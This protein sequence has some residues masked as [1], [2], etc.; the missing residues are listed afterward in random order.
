M[1][2]FLS[3]SRPTARK[4][5]ECSLCTGAIEVGQVYHRSVY[6]GDAEIYAW[7]TCPACEVDNVSGYVYDYVYYVEE[8]ITDEDALSWANEMSR[9][10]TDIEEV[11]A[12]RNYLVRWWGL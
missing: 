12:A 5:H 4:T 10:G 2:K 6:V 8:G 11:L 9:H 1:F 3:D 7:K